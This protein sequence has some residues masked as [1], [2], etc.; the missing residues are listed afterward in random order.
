MFGWIYNRF[1]GI[2]QRFGWG[3]A[4][5]LTV[6]FGFVML[7]AWDPVPLE[8]LRLKSFDLYQLLKPRTVTQRPVVIVD[9][10]EPSLEAL[11]QWPWPRTLPASSSARSPTVPSSN[12][13]P[14]VKTHP[15][16]SPPPRR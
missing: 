5:A 11:G 7:R 2:A 16:R 6:L 12:C 13:V 9:I 14:R 4:I 8:L 3:R 15:S 10:D 1:K